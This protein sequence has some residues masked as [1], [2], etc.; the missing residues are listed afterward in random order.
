MV[1][2]KCC[3]AFSF[4]LA[5]L[6][7]NTFV[8]QDLARQK[9][10]RASG[11]WCLHHPKKT[12]CAP[13]VLIPSIQGEGRRLKRSLALLLQHL[14]DPTL[15]LCVGAVCCWYAHA[16]L[17]AVPCPCA[18]VPWLERNNENRKLQFLQS[19]AHE[20]VM[21]IG[22]RQPSALT[23][24]HPMPMHPMPCFSVQRLFIGAS[25][26]VDCSSHLRRILRTALHWSV[27]F[28]KSKGRYRWLQHL[29]RGANGWES[30]DEPA[31]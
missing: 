28:I 1:A 5:E 7:Q 23:F 4:H 20:K 11:I 15:Q 25:H 29:G 12:P 14:H 30:T 8:E 26:A 6:L 10:H 19:V 18:S 13:H 27:T 22:A 9:L 24:K 17:C 2:A 3:R 21:E 16:T 31:R